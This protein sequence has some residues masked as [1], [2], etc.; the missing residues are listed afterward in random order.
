MD[1]HC[2]VCGRLWLFEHLLLQI[3]FYYLVLDNVHWSNIYGCLC[4]LACHEMTDEQCCFWDRNERGSTLFNVHACS[5]YKKCVQCKEH[6]WLLSEIS[7]VFTPLFSIAIF[8]VRIGVI[9]HS[10]YI[11][12]PHSKCFGSCRLFCL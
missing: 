6:D 9:T 1:W 12:A 10:I 8:S 3:S 4:L 2:C 11:P 7:G 5:L